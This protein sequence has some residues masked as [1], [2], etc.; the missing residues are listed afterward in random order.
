VRHPTSTYRIQFNQDF[1]FRDALQIVPYLHQLGISDLYASPIFMSR[2][3]SPHGYD[4]VDPTRLD[5]DLGSQEDFEEL[6]AALRER[7]M[8]MLLDIV[9]NHMATGSE[10]RWW[11]DVL[12]KG[13]DSSYAR[14]FDIDWRSSHGK[15]NLE[16]KV[17]LPILGRPYGE[18]LEAREIQI[19]RERGGFQVHYFDH[20][21]PMSA[22]SRESLEAEHLDRINRD[23]IALDRV[24]E[25]QFYRLAFWRL[26]SDELNYRRFFDIGELVGVRVENDE[27]LDA[28]HDL[29]RRLLAAGK[30]R[31]VRI[32][33][34]DGLYDPIRYL[35]RVR[36][37][38]GPDET[39]V[40]V[41]KILESGEQLP[42]E[43][44]V[45]GTT[46]YDFLNLVNSVF[47]DRAGLDS[48]RET[49]CEFTGIRDDFASIVYVR[50][51]RAVARL[52]AGEVGRLGKR[53]AAIAARDLIARD[54][55]LPMLSHALID[56]TSSLPVYRTYTNTPLV[57]EQDRRHIDTAM[58]TAR[59]LGGDE[60][61][62]GA[63]EFLR[64]LLVLDTT[65]TETAERWLRFVMQ[66]QQ[67]TGPAMAKGFEDTALY[68]YHPLLSLNEVGGDP[69]FPEASTGVEALHRRNLIFR[70][71]WPHTMNTTT[72]HDTKRSEGAR[73]RLNVL[74]EF[75]EEWRTRLRRWHQQNESKRKRS[76]TRAVPDRNEEVLIYQSLLGSFPLSDAE[77]PDFRKRFAEFVIKAA[78][79]AKTHSSWLE[80]HQDYEK[81]LQKF[82]ASILRPSAENRFLTDFL[83]FHRKVA[84]FGS[85]SSLA[86]VVLKVASPG[87]PDFYQG[88]E[89]WDFS[90]V[91]PDNRRPI[92]YR[93]RARSL[94]RVERIGDAASLLRNWRDG[95]IK[96][97][98][99]LRALHLR[100]ENHELFASGDYV[101]ISASGAF[102]R[103]VVAFARTDGRKW[104]LVVVPRL[105]SALT[106]PE[107][108][109]VGGFWGNTRL[110]LPKEAPRRWIN[111]FTSETVSSTNLATI[112]KT[113]PVAM[114]E[115]EE[116]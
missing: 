63:Y 64:R 71:R 51:R 90:M 67:L 30:V 53:L 66:W 24:L 22:S 45:D 8:S 57:S 44:R 29:V 41:E 107:Q 16:N 97:F 98:V 91:D 4:V 70:R 99:T 75:P 101:P 46:G 58:E 108:F 111:R 62:V 109:P 87:I 39:Y 55:P 103:N 79:E 110:R 114:L 42:D 116:V 21:F 74:S 36:H 17:L 12:E 5:P 32:D 85:I 26:A 96:L 52:F 2:P 35:N 27:V 82:A 94:R 81:L 13:P 65:D 68:V 106:R 113:F 11:M 54:I 104:I 105:S 95:G 47:V 40:A 20:R 49:Y 78:R 86:Q 61:R 34:V 23:P 37:L 102:R 3:G 7:D 31:G 14:F 9:P 83:S 77:I 73:V 115:K 84:F 25:E 59:R 93:A 50:K 80:P 18:A 1:T 43:M 10:N 69:E 100:N 60:R 15:P 89:L 76:G 19:T 72:T 33:H 92:D 48:L 28:T 38:T 56:I 88:G 112:L 6:V